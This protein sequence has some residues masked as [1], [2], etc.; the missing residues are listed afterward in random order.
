MPYN[1]IDCNVPDCRGP[2]PP[3]W[4]TGGGAARNSPSRPSRVW[5]RDTH[6]TIEWHRNNHE[7]GFYRRSLVPVKHMNDYKWHEK[8]AFEWGCFTQ[9]RYYCGKKSACGTDKEHF[10]YRN[11][12]R[13]P[14]VFPDG[15][16]VFAMVWFGG[17]HW[18]R[19]RGFFSDYWTCAFVRIE[20]G[21]LKEAHTPTFNAGKNHR[22]NVPKGKC[23]ATSNWVGQCGGYPCKRNPVW[24]SEPGAFEAGKTPAN[25]YQADIS[26]ALG[27]RPVAYSRPKGKKVRKVK[28]KAQSAAVILSKRKHDWR[29]RQRRKEDARKREHQK[30]WKEV[31]RRRSVQLERNQEKNG[32]RKAPPKPPKPTGAWGPRG[33]MLWWEKRNQ[34]WKWRN[35]CDRYAWMC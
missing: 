15:D 10:A 18:R 1:P 20:G 12:M 2:C 9:N 14:S 11:S 5:R 22:A 24:A 26:H 6:V 34:F 23:A 19:N 4:K 25:V 13:V 35:Y 31:Q 8:T 28:K 29:T 33:S 30:Y 27:K 32:K 16:Y 3:I 17:I 21:A 7:G